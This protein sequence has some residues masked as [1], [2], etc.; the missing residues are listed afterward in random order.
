MMVAVRSK[1]DRSLKEM[2][3]KSTMG[4]AETDLPTPGKPSRMV[5]EEKGEDPVTRVYLEVLFTSMRED[6]Q[7]L[8]RDLLLDLKEVRRKLGEER[9]CAHP[10]R[11]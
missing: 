3:T 1:K 2:L 11:A 6:L 8:K 9:E 4:K 10:G 5:R 7:A